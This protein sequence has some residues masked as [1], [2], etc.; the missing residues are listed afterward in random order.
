MTRLLCLLGRHRWYG[1]SVRTYAYF[2]AVTVVRRCSRSRCRAER[3]ELWQR[4]RR[5]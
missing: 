5:L 1:A 4:G 2:S 3:S